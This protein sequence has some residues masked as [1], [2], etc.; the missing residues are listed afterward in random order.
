MDLDSVVVVEVVTIENS[1]NLVEVTHLS[2]RESKY[3]NEISFSHSNKMG[4]LTQMIS[5]NPT[6]EIQVDDIHTREPVDFGFEISN[7]KVNGENLFSAT[8]NE[9]SQKINIF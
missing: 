3:S 4:T 5:S 8:F 1:F 6:I 9:K 7:I 2:Y